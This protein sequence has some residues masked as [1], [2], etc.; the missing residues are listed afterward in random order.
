MRCKC[1]SQFHAIMRR[2]WTSNPVKHTSLNKDLSFSHLHGSNFLISV[3]SLVHSIFLCSPES[4]AS[5]KVETTQPKTYN[6][7]PCLTP[8]LASDHV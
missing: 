8:L 7:G 4:R 1:L 2:C 5:T 6:L 3:A